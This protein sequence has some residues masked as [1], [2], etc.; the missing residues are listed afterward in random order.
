MQAIESPS[1]E[2]SIRFAQILL[3]SFGHE[4]LIKFDLMDL[5]FN[6]VRCVLEV[7][8]YSVHRQ[9][10]LPTQVVAYRVESDRAPIGIDNQSL[11][12]APERVRR[13]S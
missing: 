8:G 13:A 10:D 2:T 11:C 5:D 9:A 3:E 12:A 6:E 7:A 4:P 1:P